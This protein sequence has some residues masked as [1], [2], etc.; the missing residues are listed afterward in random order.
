[1][2]STAPESAHRWGQ[3]RR[4]T[5]IDVRLQY[6]GRINRSDL[7]DFFAISVPQATADLKRYQELAPGNVTYD[8]RLRV[9]VTLKSFEPVFAH[10]TAS[11]YLDDLARLARKMI[12]STESF[13]GFIPPTGVV[14]T[15]ARAI[16]PSE[17]A[18]LVQAIRDKVTLKVVYQSMDMPEP[19]NWTISPH[20]V[21]L[22]GLRWHT[23]AWCHTRNIFRDFAIGRLK[24]L[25]AVPDIDGP[26]PDSD[27]GWTTHVPVILVPHPDLSPSQREMVMRDYEMENGR[28]VLDCRKA[29]LF[30]TLRH[31]NLESAELKDAARQHVVV[32]NR[33]DV[34][35]WVKEDRDGSLSST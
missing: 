35:R 16:T 32:E 13:V 10:R 20:A 27:E 24:V 29:M 21:G 19:S 2:E 7:I 3:A 9:Y 5:F 15:P 11:L 23:R 18:T 22:D 33:D 30:Y 1:M 34:N 14:A 28:T 17:V 12:N 26:S 8:P 4:L 25:E 6:D 31:L